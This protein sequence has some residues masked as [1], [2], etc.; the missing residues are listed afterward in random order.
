MAMEK[1]V[2]IDLDNPQ[3]YRQY[4][5]DDM[6]VHIRNFPRLCE[7]AWQLSQGFHLPED[8]QKVKKIVILGMGGSAIGG[9]LI[10]GLA[11]NEAAAPV[12]VCRD[13][14][15][16]QYVDEETLVIA[17]SY[18]GMTEETLSA[19]EQACRTPAKK[20]A[21]TT[22]G[23]LKSL[24]ES[25]DVP[26]FTIDY[27]SSPRAALPFSF[28]LL[29][30][31]LQNLKV[32][33]DK[34]VEV[35]AAI[36]DLHALA[37][38]IAENVPSKSNAAKAL[39]VKL[40]GRLPVIYGAG[41]TGAVAQRWKTQLNENSKTMAFYEIFSE[42]NHNSIMGYQLPEMIKQCMVVMLDSELLHERIRLRYEITQTLLK[43]AGIPF[44][45]LKAEGTTPLS[46]MMGLVFVGDY[47]SYYLAML[48]GID[49]THIK[50]INFLKNSL[51]GK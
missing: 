27:K 7:Q 41:I 22:G 10:A 17:N 11:I 16:P 29:L 48:N 34:S 23:K 19:F 51:A 5:P 33:Q 20:L 1:K 3:T 45:V 9:D 42:L 31:L 37:S 39:A 25:L 14:F 6:L 18:S 32:F 49:P 4:D 43:Q 15:L 44:Q 2:Q 46:H 47:V 24:C 21:I 28:F 30:G 12:A 13:Y 35:T 50:S 36:K 40:N 8:Y 38:K 26:V